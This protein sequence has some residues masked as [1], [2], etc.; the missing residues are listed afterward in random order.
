MENLLNSLKISTMI[1]LTLGLAQAQVA[2]STDTL[3]TM[4]SSDW[5][6]LPI[7]Y[8]TP[9]TKLAIAAGGLYFFRDGTDATRARPSAIAA[10]IEY[11]QL[12]QMKFELSPDISLLKGEYRLTGHIGYSKFPAMYYGSVNGTIVEERYTPQ[13][14]YVNLSIQ[15]S[16][17]PHLTAGCMVTYSTRQ[18]MAVEPA[19]VLGAGDILGSR[20]GFTSGT[21][22]TLTLDERDNSFFP[23]SGRYYEGSYTAYRKML[24][25]DYTFNRWKADVRDYYPVG[26]SQVIAVQRYVNIV[27]GDA[28]F[29]ELPTF[30][31]K[32][33]LRGYADGYYR[34]K[35]VLALQVDYRVTP[36]WWRLGFAAFASVGEVAANMDRLSLANVQYSAGFGVRYLLIEKE[37]LSL[38]FDWAWGKGSS[39]F[40]ITIN[41]AF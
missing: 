9:E 3:N 27:E 8:Y 29:H 31:G 16:V 35:N 37:K 15:K 26:V 34:D 7:L 22:V 28:P 5:I 25:S 17:G 23:T 10:T 41:E 18:M 40:Y 4:A 12:S 2:P 36:L 21:G 39:G 6:A 13:S 24:G 20:G 32:E 30:G 1:M 11:T 33:I 19:G 38:R 14:T